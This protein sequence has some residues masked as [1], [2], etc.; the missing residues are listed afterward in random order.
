MIRVGAGKSGRSS[1]RRRQ[2]NVV[3]PNVHAPP[4]GDADPVAKVRRVGETGKQSMPSSVNQLTRH[5]FPQ[6]QKRHLMTEERRCFQCG[7]E[8][9]QE[10][11]GDLCG[12]CL[13]Q[14]PGTA[15]DTQTIGPFP[16]RRRA[17]PSR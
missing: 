2:H 17:Q 9:A 12:A 5:E 15:A 1:V 6:L 3:Q 7:A 8:I 13:K 14:N 4:F 10:L 16:E 11:E